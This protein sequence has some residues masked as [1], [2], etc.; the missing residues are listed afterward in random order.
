MASKTLPLRRFPHLAFSHAQEKGRA[1]WLL[2][3]LLL[4]A[5]SEEEPDSPT[6]SPTEAP[7][8]TPVPVASRELTVISATEADLAVTF[9][10]PH[11]VVLKFGQSAYTYT[12]TVNTAAASQ[13]IHL[14]GLKPETTWMWQLFVDGL[15]VDEGDFQLPAAPVGPF[16]VVFDNAHAQQAG[17]ADWVIDND[18]PAPSP[19]SPSSE[20]DWRGAYSSWGYDLLKSGRYHVSTNKSAFSDSVLAKVDA[21]IVPE[22][23]SPFTSAEISALQRYVYNGGGLFLMANHSGSDRDNDGWDAVRIWE[24]VLAAFSPSLGISFREVRETD[25]PCSNLF[26]DPLDPVMVGPF[27][28]VDYMGFNSGSELDISISKNS[29][30]QGLAWPDGVIQGYV[31]AW[32]VR[33]RYGEGRVVAISDSSPADDG[34]GQSGDELYDSW[35]LSDQQN[36]SFHLN[37]TAYLVGDVGD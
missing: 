24:S 34:T 18:A 10:Q 15:V 28:V 22:P 19:S 7:A 36:D 1:L 2:P 16:N 27:G 26:P 21:L 29:T 25:D 33:G 32:A 3:A 4:V 5:C 6:P 12:R 14:Y 37:A 9:A 8:G 13:L 20:S 30:L 17:N 31:E 23:N 35:N 11:A